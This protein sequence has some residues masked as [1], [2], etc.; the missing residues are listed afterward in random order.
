MTRKGWFKQKEQHSLAA[1]GVKTKVIRIP[2]QIK[3]DETGTP[4]KR[5][6]IVYGTKSGEVNSL[7]CIGSDDDFRKTVDRIKMAA[8]QVSDEYGQT[9]DFFVYDTKTNEYIDIGEDY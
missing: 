2:P 6:L 5:Y 9:P 3:I 8:D 4:L 1:K 7:V